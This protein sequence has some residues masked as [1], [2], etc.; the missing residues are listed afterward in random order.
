MNW[1]QLA[2]KVEDEWRRF[3]GVELDH[4]VSFLI[5]SDEDRLQQSRV[6]EQHTR[7]V[8]DAAVRLFIKD[9]AWPSLSHDER[10]FLQK[11][12]YY[13][14]LLMDNFSSD[15]SV[16]KGVSPKTSPAGLSDILE[17]LLI[18]LWRSLGLP[19]WLE[20]Q[21]QYYNGCAAGNV[22]DNV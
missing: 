21:T 1:E 19:L 9:G 2:K 8:V 16:P 10:Y 22:F 4:I 17:W 18:D 15:D 14:W 6:R 11:R 12:L 7:P 3:E 5:R 13:G 20:A